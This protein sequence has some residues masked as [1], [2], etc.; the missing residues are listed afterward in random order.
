M[1]KRGLWEWL[2]RLRNPRIEARSRTRSSPSNCCDC[3]PL[4]ETSTVGDDSGRPWVHVHEN[5]ATASKISS[6]SVYIY[7]CIYSICIYI[8]RNKFY[9]CGCYG[10]LGTMPEKPKPN[11]CQPKHTTIIRMTRM[12]FILIY[13]DSI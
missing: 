10:I 6:R 11:H 5:I 7:I 4:C 12:Y 2:W 1:L 9:L 13:S 8:Y 3:R